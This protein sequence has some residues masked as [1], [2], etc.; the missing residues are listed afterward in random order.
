MQ[1]TEP[2]THPA[3]LDT[4]DGAPRVRPAP[5]RPTG[6]RP[7]FE[8]LDLVE[9]VPVAGPPAIFLVGPLVL[10]ALMVAGP[11]V[12]LLTIVALLIAATML[13]ALAA[14]ALAS[15]YL[16]VRHIRGRRAAAR[17]S[18]SAPAPRVV[19]LH[20]RRAAA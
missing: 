3:G 11:F 12:A 14:A 13:V 16:L 6:A 4:A 9:F 17:T 18:S 7:L 10:F 19:R 5:E 20:S 8:P 15:P 1:T 2:I